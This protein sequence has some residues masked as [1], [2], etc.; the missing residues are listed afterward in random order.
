MNKAFLDESKPNTGRN[1]S[2]AAVTVDGD[3][4]D[5]I[6]SRIQDA[7]GDVRELKFAETGDGRQ[8]RAALRVI[9]IVKEFADAAQLRVDTLSWDKSDSR[10]GVAE[11]DDYANIGRML[12]HLLSN[13]LGKWDGPLQW[14]LVPDEQDQLDYHTTARTVNAAMS[15]DGRA[16]HEILFIQPA[17]SHESPIVQV[18]DMFAGIACYVRDLTDAIAQNPSR[19]A[20][21]RNEVL[22]SLLPWMQSHGFVGYRA[23]EGVFTERTCPVNFWPYRPQGDYDRAPVKGE[24]DHVLAACSAEGCDEVF[25]ALKPWKIPLC[26]QHYAAVVQDREDAEQRTRQE[27]KQRTGSHYCGNCA[28]TYRETEGRKRFN[29][30]TYEHDLCC[31]RCGEMLTELDPLPYRPE[32]QRETPRY[33]REP[34]RPDARLP[35]TNRREDDD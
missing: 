4:V 19:S 12:H 13:A 21:A 33:D 26:R 9:E 14:T 27:E 18:A 10:N 11:R 25:V 3:V 16:W 6:E 23:G 34:R 28:V 17:V 8:K 5:E 31:P 30:L 20:R 15:R 22:M 29:E 32:P 24:S 2:V 7:L 1:G 35:R